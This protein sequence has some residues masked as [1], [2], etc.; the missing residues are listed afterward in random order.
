M[1]FEKKNERQGGREGRLQ[2][3]DYRLQIID[4]RLRISLAGLCYK[5]LNKSFS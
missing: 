2:I 5:V 3:I 4:Y 1:S